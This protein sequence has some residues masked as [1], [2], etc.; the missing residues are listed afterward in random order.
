VPAAIEH[1]VVTVVRLL[2]RR[3]LIEQASDVGG[4]PTHRAQQIDLNR[5][6]RLREQKKNEDGNASTPQ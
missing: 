5:G 1:E 2:E 4:Q 6:S 3:R